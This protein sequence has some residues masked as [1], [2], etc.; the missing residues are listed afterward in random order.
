MAGKRRGGHP[1]T[2]CRARAGRRD[3]QWCSVPAGPVSCCTRRSATAWRR[4]STAREPRPLRGLI[5]QPVASSKVTVVDNGT[6]AGRRGSLNVDD[7]GSPT[8]ETVL[9]ENGVLQGLS[10]RQAL[11]PPDGHG[12]HRIGPPRELPLHPHAA[13]DQHLHAG[14]ARDEPEDIMR[15]V[16]TGF[17]RRTS[18][19]GRWTSPTASLSSPPRRLT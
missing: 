10:D 3:G 11:R 6:M 4:T 9:I 19:A 12:Q 16:H 15:S 13:H 8:Q 7:E 18:A 14:A 5:G 17:T 2:E 1:A